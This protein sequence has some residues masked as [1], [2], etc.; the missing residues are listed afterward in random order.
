MVD[1]KKVSLMTKAAI[2]EQKEKKN[3][4]EIVKYRRK[5]YILY[6]LIGVFISVTLAYAILAGAVMFMIVMA[7]DT[8][9]LNISE[10]ILIAAGI[11]VGYLVV[12]ILYY[13]ISHKYYG[14]KHIKARQK[15][16]GYLML[17]SELSNINQSK[18]KK[19]GEAK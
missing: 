11:L 4:L 10:M 6:H 14:D 18:E 15:V 13:M 7:Y 16:R 9:I 8:I 19:E 5:D 17:L 2:F 3:T 1:E 12:L